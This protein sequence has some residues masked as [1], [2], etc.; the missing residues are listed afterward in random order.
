MHAYIPR[1]LLISCIVYYL[2]CVAVCSCQFNHF[3]INER[4]T[5][6]TGDEVK[7]TFDG[8]L[9]QSQAVQPKADDWEVYEEQLCFYMVANNITDA[10]KKRSILLRVCGEQTSKLLRSL[11]SEGKLDVDGITYDSL[12]KLLQS[13]YK[14]KQSVVVH[15]F[16]F[17]TC[18]RK[19]AESIADYI[20]ALR[21]LALNCNFGSQERLEELLRDRLI[22]GVNHE[23]IQRKLLSEGDI[24]YADADARPVYRVSGG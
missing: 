20:A 14:K 2:L 3:V 22:C 15:R 13:H 4:V 18:S 21:E 6:F 23:G 9:R 24:S 1:G 7:L 12:A 8:Y 11:V 16:N 5:T 10:I 17:N 19:S